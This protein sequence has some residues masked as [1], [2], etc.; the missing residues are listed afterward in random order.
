MNKFEIILRS[1]RAFGGF[2]E[3]TADDD[4]EIWCG[5]AKHYSNV[6]RDLPGKERINIQID[7]SGL[8]KGTVR[9]FT[10]I[11]TAHHA[12]HGTPM[13]TRISGSLIEEAT[14]DFRMVNSFMI[15][16]TVPILPFRVAPATLGK[17]FR[18]FHL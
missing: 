6:S 12:T 15:F 14:A 10:N 5:I 8:G 7:W 3:L 1:P 2:E 13:G 9:R 4:E 17:I 16:L 11:S 18:I